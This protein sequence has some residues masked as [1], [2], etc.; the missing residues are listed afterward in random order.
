MDSDAQARR[1]ARQTDRQQAA[2]MF[3][4]VTNYRLQR[5][6]RPI[7][8]RLAAVEAELERLQREGFKS[9]D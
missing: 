4:P 3:G 1:D 9:S 6:L 7:L 5:E 2:E 8:K